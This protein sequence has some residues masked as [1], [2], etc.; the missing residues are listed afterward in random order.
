MFKFNIEDLPYKFFVY[1]L[2]QSTV[3]QC[4]M[5]ANKL[6]KILMERN[7]NSTGK[8]RQEQKVDTLQKTTCHDVMVFN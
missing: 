3:A 6:N 2:N 5:A 7:T 1:V 4:A 8:G